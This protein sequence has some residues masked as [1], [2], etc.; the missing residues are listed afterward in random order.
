MKRLV[1]S[2][3]VVV[4]MGGVGAG[5]ARA[6]DAGTSDGACYGNGTCNAGLSCSAGVCVA[7]QAG[8][9]GGACYGNGT[10]NAGMTCDPASQTCVA[11]AAP[12]T[13][14]PVAPSITPAATTAPAGGGI[15]S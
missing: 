13:P 8:T 10:C 2:I 15:D 14:A 6:Q 4:T 12:T 9:L 7:A 3:G 5:A 11:A 1:L